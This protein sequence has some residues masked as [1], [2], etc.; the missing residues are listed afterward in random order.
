MMAGAVLFEAFAGRQAWSGAVL[1]GWPLVGLVFS[2][3]ITRVPAADPTRR[4]QANF[5]GDLWAQIRHDA[6]RI[7]CSG[8]PAS[9]ISISSSSAALVQ[10][11]VIDYGKNVLQ[12]GEVHTTQLWR[13]WR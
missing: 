10:L 4:F 9:A 3:G 6:A 5:L 7:A 8:W 11:G 12:V 1:V 2:L 13:P